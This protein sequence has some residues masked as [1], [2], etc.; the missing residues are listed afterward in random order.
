VRQTVFK[1]VFKYFIYILAAF[2]IFLFALYF[3]LWVIT[4]KTIADSA[5]NGAVWIIEH[6]TEALGD[7]G[8]IL[9]PLLFI[10]IWYTRPDKNE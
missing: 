2:A 5:V 8:L 10:Y 6:P 9:L 4:T 1:L 7:L 3:C